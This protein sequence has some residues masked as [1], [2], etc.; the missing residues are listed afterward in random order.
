MTQNRTTLLSFPCKFPIK[1]MGKRVDHFAQE[2]VKVILVNA[3]DFN[4]STLEM[5]VSSNAAYISLIDMY[6]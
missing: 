2:V 5:R 3:P 1:V 6:N 4:A